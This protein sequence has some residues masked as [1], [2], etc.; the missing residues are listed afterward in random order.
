M[1][2]ALLGRTLV[3][4]LWAGILGFAGCTTAPTTAN[5]KANLEDEAT[6]AL[7]RL[8][9]E[10]AGLPPFL[11]KAYAYALF[12]SVSKGGIG[13]GAA[14]GWGVV[15]EQGQKIGYARMTQATLGAQ[16]GGQTFAELVAFENREALDRFRSG[17]LNFAAN[18][19]AVALKNG[20]AASAKY[21]N[22][23][24]V[25]LLSTGGLMFEATVGGQQFIFDPMTPVPPPST[26][27][28]QPS[29]APAAQPAPGAQQPPAATPAQK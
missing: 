3:F 20:A 24:A 29:T 22:G 18:A 15:R 9:R 8:S 27:T 23:V 16:L 7:S 6:V 28:A 10:D 21:D 5:E 11:G 1:K 14:E 25:F 2:S 4:G 12:P 17:K 13:I 26:A 19:S